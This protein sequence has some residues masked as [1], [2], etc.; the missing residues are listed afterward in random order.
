MRVTVRSPSQSHI[1]RFLVCLLL[2]SSLLSAAPALAQTSVLTQHNDAARTGANL[3]ETVL[4]TTNVN[5]SQFGKL[6]ERAVD[7]EIYAQ[8]LYVPGVNVPGVGVRNVIYVVTNSDSVYAF[9]ADDPAASM[10]LWRVAYANAAAGIL[11]ISHTDVGQA[12]GTYQDFA[13]NIG[14]TG[15]PVIDGASQTMYFVTKTKENG[16]FTQR[17]HA[18]DI[19]DGSE[20]PGSPKLI[21]ASVPGTGDGRDANNNIAFNARTQNQ[22]AALLLDHGTVYIAWASYCDQGPYH[23]WILG[24]DATT[25]ALVTIYNSSPDGG[26]GGIWQSG[27]G[28]AA[29]P[30]GNLYALTGNGTFNGATG[31]SSFGNSFLKVSPTGTLIDWFTPYNWSFLNATDEDLGIQNPLLVPN[32][33]LVIGGGKEGVLYV[34][35][36][37]NMGHNQANDNNQIV[38]SFQA[39]SSG[40]MNGSPVFWNGPNYGPAIYL[41]PAGDPLKV[42]QFASGSFITPA[43]AQS[44]ALAPGGMPG[45]TLAI[46]ANA[47]SA[48]TGILWATLSRGG[49][50]NHAPQPGV[51]RA[52]DASNVTRELWNSEQN[53][54]RDRLA[55]FSKFTGPTIADGKVFVATLSNKLVV[56]GLLSPSPGN[57]APVVEAGAA[58]TITLPDTATLT[59][60]ASDD[61]NP[62]PPG[63]LTLT[64]SLASGPAAVTFSAPNAL[65]TTAT[66]SVPG[67]YTIRLSAFDGEAT[68]SDDV[69][70]TVNAPEGS[71]TGLLAQY[72]ND[73]GSG[74]YFTA[75]ALTR[76]DATVD[77]DWANASP[78]PLVQADNFSVR[79]SGQVQAP[80]AGTYTFTTQS[81]EGVRVWVNGVLLIDNWVD[82]T[83]ATNSGSISLVAGQ[84]YDIR[85]DYYDHTSLA[86]I[87]L[88]WAYPGQNGQIVPQ[89]VL[90][91][92][93]PVN[94]PPAVNAGP[95]RTIALPATASLAGAVQDDGLPTPANLTITWSK[96]SGR[97]DSDG[98]TVVFADPHAPATTATFGAS[99][100]YVLRL[101]ASDGAVTVS[102]DV[103]VTVLPPPVVG[104]GTGLWGEYFN[105]PNN[106]TH[107]VTPVLKRVDATL[108]FD[109]ASAAPASGVGVD[110]FSVRW[111]GQV[112]APQD[113]SYIFQTTADDGVRLWVN[114]ALVI[115]NWVDQGATPKTSAAIALVAGTKYDIKM[116]YYEHGGSAVAKL[117]WTY[118]GQA[119]APIAQTQLY[120]PANQ[121]PV[122]N[123]GADKTITLPATASMAGTASDD[124]LPVPPGTLTVSW[125]KT[126]GPGTVTFSNASALNTTA[127]FSAAG[128]YVLRLTASDSVLSTSDDV[129]VVVNQATAN[130]LT[131]QYYNDPSTG[132]THFVTLVLTRTDNTV[133]FSWGAASPATGVTANNF[134]V[135]WTGQVQA[136]VSGTYRFSTVSDDGVRLWVNGTQVINNWTDHS[137]TTNTSAGITLTA[138]VKYT[139]TMEFYERGGD[140]VAKLQWSYPGQST[141]IIPQ[142]RL[143]H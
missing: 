134:S 71:G 20:R 41:W 60:T 23:G 130:G 22:R 67:V 125:T 137:S 112:Q 68:S 127:T 131:A 5:V 21:Q 14:I 77:F 31:G 86:T 19:R 94:H 69:I 64:W 58:Q 85:V 62:V 4:T 96:I 33:N 141:Q 12:C 83:L 9:D 48:G 70:V 30:L 63:A 56:Y 39:S 75:L 111:T 66:F 13:G 43:T 92:A 17:L 78:D 116:E 124:G 34:V 120:L 119:M 25:L 42:F 16:T 132:T 105:D 88:S 35:D 143:F 102:D 91:P 98:G 44:T 80:V 79:W 82:H 3:T 99:G 40:R 136:P 2:L 139:I 51:L 90:Y 26:L 115:D 24:Y 95:D 101:T 74:V 107:F 15:T 128:T 97:E 100:I 93:P 11:P 140:A 76:T 87:K 27:G 54:T 28:L 53:A 18:L 110:N 57:T 135:R 109:W 29:D 126:S 73:A 46:S 104:S 84:R 121:A 108:N 6:F 114:G 138:G 89:W 65:T 47:G 123:A 37:T 36:R 32:T 72:F 142:S 61:G 52:Y 106:G 50:A 133:N 103:T 8:P 49:D 118:P 55:N 10:P 7:D 59:G 122:V 113:G 117:A 38:Q 1:L 129:T 81:D 45:G